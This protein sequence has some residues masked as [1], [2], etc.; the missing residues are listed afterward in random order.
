MTGRAVS[1]VLMLSLAL[2]CGGGDG[3]SEPAGNGG[4]TVAP[5]DSIIVMPRGPME[6]ALDFSNR[7]GMND[8]SCF[9][10]LTSGFSDTLPSDSLSPQQIFGRWRAFDAGGRL[11]AIS[12][13]PRGRMTSYHCSIRRMEMPAINR[14]DFLLEEEEWL[15]DGFG[16]ELPRETEDSLTVEQLADMVIRYPQ[17]RREMHIARMLYDD[18]IIDSVQNYASLD[19]A[20]RAG[21]DYRDFILDLQDDSY[22]ILA[23][24]NIRRAGK[25]QIMQDRAG[26][27][28]SGLPSDLASLVNI[29]REMAYISKSVLSSRHE[30][31]QHLY[32]TGDWVEPDISGDLERLGGFRDFFLAV[33]DLVE[34]R[35]S[36]SRTWPVLLTA[37][38]SEPLGQVQIDL[39]P[40]QLDQK[41][42]NEVGVTVWRAL[43]VELNGDSDPERVVYWAGNLY[44]FQGTPAGYRLAWR[45]YEDYDSDYHADFV[46]QPSGRPGC[47]EVT[48]TGVD[49]DYE[50]FLGYSDQGTPLFRR[51]RASM[52][53]P[54]PDEGEQP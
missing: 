2:G 46:S 9:E 25:F 16:V 5:R 43:A 14:I 51:I 22:G 42:E 40:H 12:E 53:G 13:T 54:S 41:S 50:Y 26:A 24:C 11:T 29:W 8:P 31:M 32:A 36:L 45:T 39:D 34:S 48:F 17:V 10:L 44:L 28:A 19:A 20:M 1:A 7:L 35:D 23:Q 30:A 18:C 15:I 21:T 47:R 3:S 27:S 38:S 52:V 4:T 49:G 37:G 33:S 6:V